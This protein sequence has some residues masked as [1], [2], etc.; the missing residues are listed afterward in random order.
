MER[1]I[2]PQLVKWKSSLG[3]KPLLLK[4]ARQTGKTW[5]LKEFGRREF[6]N[7][8][9]C[10]FEAE[11]LLHSLFAESLRPQAVLPKLSSFS[12]QEILPGETLL[13]L[14]EIQLSNNALNSLKYFCEEAPEYA[15]AAAG[16]L[17]GL[18]VSAPKSFPVGKVDLLDLYPMT[19]REFLSAI[20]EER[21]RELVEDPAVRPLDELF[22]ARLTDA[23]RTYY[24]VGGMPEAV[25]LFAS[26]RSAEKARAVQLTILNAYAMDFVKHVPPPDIP[27]V[28][29]IWESIPRHL[30]HEHK[31]FVFSALAK[32]A[33]ARDYENALQ[34][35]IDASLVHRCRGVEHV[36]VPLTAFTD[37]D[38]F[39]V[40]AL[41][42]GLLG[43]LARLSP[44]TVIQGD[45][46]FSTFHGAFV[47]NYVA[48]QLVAIQPQID[49]D[50]H[51]WR[52]ESRK[53]EV[54]F[55]V[56]V[57]GRVIPLEV[58]AGINPRS[59][60]LSTYGERHR[61]PLLVRS[62]L[63]NLR[64]DGAVLN[65]PLYAI[66]SLPAYLLRRLDKEDEG[67]KRPD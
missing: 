22:H 52:S 13:V 67:S 2:Y 20:G 37:P 21:L 8:V 41:D 60:S 38:A 26:H 59:K 63:L 25:S 11:P 5:L 46:L 4:G 35:L 57:N 3:R 45:E 56:M 29:A 61:P 18:K 28:A 64:H 16:S 19:L 66:E 17:I 23:L 40:Y 34:W 32:S 47:E 44:D 43:A 14:D 7:L 9:Y 15:V 30:A 36:E 62:T 50:L 39:K 1:L 24:V 48:Q 65:I 6:R 12:G 33:R 58:K 54:D 42:V 10:N 55:L 49:R 31:R 53:A 27:K 51:Y